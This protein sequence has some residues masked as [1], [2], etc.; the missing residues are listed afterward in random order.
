MRARLS[1]SVVGVECR[2]ALVIEGEGNEREAWASLVPGVVEVQ[3]Q[4]AALAQAQ[5][6]SGVPQNSA[7][8]AA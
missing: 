7:L 2:P 8:A 3:A 1:G 4:Q 5:A 6:A